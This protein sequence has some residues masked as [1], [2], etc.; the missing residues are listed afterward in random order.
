[1]TTFSVLQHALYYLSLF[2]FVGRAESLSLNWS[3][4]GS[5]HSSHTI[6][7]L[8]ADIKAHQSKYTPRDRYPLY[9][10]IQVL[11]IQKDRLQKVLTSAIH[12]MFQTVTSLIFGPRS[13]D[14]WKFA[15]SGFWPF[16]FCFL[17]CCCSKYEDFR[18]AH[19]NLLDLMFEVRK[20]SE[21]W[22][23]EKSKILIICRDE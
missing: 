12:K 17:F 15:N 5:S 22:L 21:S 7:L 10:R 13:V 2:Q 16:F 1:L 19:S 14:I 9:S 4:D 11:L 6:P 18:N 20:S 3:R 8:R 23:N